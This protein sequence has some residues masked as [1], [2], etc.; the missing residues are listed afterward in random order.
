MCDAEPGLR[1][2]VADLSTV[3]P[4][5]LPMAGGEVM[6]KIGQFAGRW[7]QAAHKVIPFA[8]VV[9]GGARRGHGGHR[10]RRGADAH[11]VVVVRR[12]EPLPLL[13]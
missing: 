3:E 9:G 7:G 5:V 8:P 4:A 13:E 1:P 6:A 11:C 10:R 12:F 2:A